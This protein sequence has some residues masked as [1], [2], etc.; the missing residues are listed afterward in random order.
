MRG[1]VR[2][3][4]PVALLLLAALALALALAACGSGGSTTGGSTG[5]AEPAKEGGTETAAEKSGSGEEEAEGGGSEEAEVAKAEAF[6]AKYGSGVGGPLPTKP[7]TPAPGKEIWILSCSQAASGCAH[8]SAA[9]L[10][11]VEV[12]GWKGKVVD[13]EGSTSKWNAAIEQARVAGVDGV[14]DIA[15][16]CAPIKTALERAK[17]AG[18]PVVSNGSE[19]CDAPSQGG[20]EALFTHTLEPEEGVE[21]WTETDLRGGELGA[22]WAIAHV[23]GKKEA[24][25]FTSTDVE[26]IQRFAEGFKKAFT[27]P[28][29]SIVEEVPFHLT[30]LGSP[31]TQKAQTAMLKHPDANVLESAPDPVA[32]PVAQAIVNAGKT[33]SVYST[34]LLG[35]PEN[36]ELIREGRG[37]SMSAVW[38]VHWLGWAVTDDMI[39]I[40]NGEKPV[41]SG[42]GTGIVD[43]EHLPKEG[44]EYESPVDFEANYEKLWGVK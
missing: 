26:N 25:E 18:M 32:T 42:F 21:S 17:K 34:S 44:N 19:D 39:R 43:A 29:C 20:T 33:E 2:R 6:L 38:D 31:L 35:E 11:A 28:E 5:E 10:E 22:E 15:V 40:L 13:G 7:T 30:E 1:I 14:I 37:Q 41:Y 12:A 9:T 16:D 27:C 24:I 36:I 23:P 4:A 8:A 3:G